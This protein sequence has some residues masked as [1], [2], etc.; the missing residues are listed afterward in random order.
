MRSA[1]WGRALTPDGDDWMVALVNLNNHTREVRAGWA[2]LEWPLNT[3]AEVHDVWASTEE[4]G[5]MAPVRA[6]ATTG[7]AAEVPPHG[8]A[9]LRVR[10]RRRQWR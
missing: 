4:S 1:L 6:L 9:L 8:T 5:R 7:L 3:T 2:A 10:R